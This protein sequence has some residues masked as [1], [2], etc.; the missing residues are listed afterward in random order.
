WGGCFGF[1]VG[2]VLGVWFVLVAVFVLWVWLWL[3]L[4]VG[5]CWVVLE[6]WLSCVVG[7]VFFRGGWGR[8]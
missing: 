3:V 8:V 7:G 2:V 6:F 4:V 1:G 5:L